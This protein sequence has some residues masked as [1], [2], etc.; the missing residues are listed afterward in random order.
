MQKVFGYARVSSK[1]QNLERQTESLKAYGINERDIYTDKA[2]GKNFDR[3][4]YQ[5][6][7]NNL[8]PGDTLIVHEL[9]R[10]GRNKRDTLKEIQ[11][12]RDNNIRFKALNLPTT[13]MDT[14]DNLMLDTINNI[15]IELYTMMAQQELE[16]RDKRQQEGI[17]EAK[18]QGKHLGRPK[19]EYP[20]NWNEVYNQW[21][22]KEITGVKAMELLQLKRT[23]FYKLVGL[24]E[25]SNE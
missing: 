22:S 11:W 16:T 18:K 3:E 8:R 9:D 4:K 5:Q 21:K 14:N 19:A 2:T 25:D 13:L 15:V 23:T 1:D 6:L 20:N 17:K 10:L 12:L 24:Y 7:K